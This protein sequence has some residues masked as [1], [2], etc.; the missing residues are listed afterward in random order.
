[1]RSQQLS[2]LSVGVLPAVIDDLEGLLLGPG[3]VV[4]MGGTARLSAVVNAEWRAAALLAELV[5][6]GLTGERTTAVSGVV[7]VRTQFVTA[8]GPLAARWVRGAVKAA[9]PELALTGPRLRLWLI[10]SGRYDGAGYHL[11]LAPHDPGVWPA[12][13]RALAAAGLPGTFQETPAVD[14]A[15]RITGRR[16]LARLAEL[17]GDPPPGAGPCDWPA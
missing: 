16:R 3:Q 9:P 4:R 14:P 13:G 10:G 8:L 12:A 6:R 2:F 1:V 5:A 15:Y 17:V 11:G 7:A